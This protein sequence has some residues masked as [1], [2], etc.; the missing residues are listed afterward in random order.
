[1][2][3]MRAFRTALIMFFCVVVLAGFLPPDNP[4]FIGLGITGL[5]ACLSIRQDRK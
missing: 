1:M 5:V 3:F 2:S 4:W